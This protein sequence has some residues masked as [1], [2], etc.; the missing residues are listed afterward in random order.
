MLGLKKELKVYFA[1]HTVATLANTLCV[2]ETAI[3]RINN[4][5]KLSKN[6]QGESPS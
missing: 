3:S 2:A 5:V 1:N 4:A 6:I